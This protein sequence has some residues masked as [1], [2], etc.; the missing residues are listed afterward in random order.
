MKY[1]P[2]KIKVDLGSYRHYWR[3]IPKSGKTQLFRD[4]LKEAYG[5]Y[6]YGLLISPGNESGHRALDGVYA[7]E[8]PTWEDFVTIV[9]D[10]VE[11][12][13]DNEF[14][15]I[16]IDTCDEL[17]S[18]ASDKVMKIHF[19]RKGEKAQSLNASHG[20][21]GNGAKMVVELIEDQIKRIENA[22]YGMVFISHT[23]FKDLKEKGSEE[24]YQ[25]LTTNMESRYDG[26]FSNKADI[27]ATIYIQRDIK[28]EKLLGTERYIYFRTDGFIDAGS[29]F[30][31]MP[32]RVILSAKNYLQAFEQGVRSSFVDPISTDKIQEIKQEEIAEKEK[33]AQKYIEKEKS[34][35]SGGSIE[36]YVAKITE[37]LGSIDAETKRQ[38]REE[39]KN[40]GLPTAFKDLKDVEILKNILIIV[41]E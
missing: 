8:T 40:A 13:Q 17:V 16:A 24:T 4:L 41:S 37:V 33:N 29:R 21:F 19:Q 34:V 5:D 15:L 38:K 26:I 32:E 30:S 1:A 2:N 36:E 20:G 12:K 27:I 6:K 3:G 35:F 25:Q 22:G 23:K 31:N 11:N 10:L 18:I 28:D 14:K 39:L 7:V 9:D